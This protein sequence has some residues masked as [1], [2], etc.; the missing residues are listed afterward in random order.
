MCTSTTRRHSDR[1]ASVQNEIDEFWKAVCFNKVITHMRKTY[2]TGIDFE[3]SALLKLYERLLK[4]NNVTYSPHLSRFTEDILNAVPE[5][6]K[7]GVTKQKVKPYLKKDIDNLVKEVM[8]PNSFVEQLNKIVV[9]IRKAISRQQNNFTG[10]FSMDCQKNSVPK[11]LL[12]LI[13]MLVDGTDHTSKSSQA[14]LTCAQLIVSNYKPNNTGAEDKTTYHSQKRET[15]LVLYNA[16]NLYG[17]FRSEC[18]ITNQFHM[19][20]SVPYLRILKI[21]KHIADA[22]LQQFKD[23]KCFVPRGTQKGVFTVIAKD[24]IDLNS[25]SSTATMDYHG[26][27]F[28]LI[29]MHSEESEGTVYNY[30]Y[31]R[32]IMT[33]IH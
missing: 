21:T 13:S 3:A 17:R 4:E 14:T 1:E 6:E 8:N 11:E 32:W 10:K 29:Q 20:L 24:N 30:I 19:G 22:M 16:L 31:I 5:L 33:S 27:G 15:P 7:R 26:T 18:I 12:S 2:V 9:P 23:L 25:R 28:S